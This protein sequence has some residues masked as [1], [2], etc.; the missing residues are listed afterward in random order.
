MAGLRKKGVT[1]LKILASTLLIY[2]IYTRIDLREVAE[3]LKNTDP[4][5]ILVSLLF[6]LLSKILSAIRL[7]LFFY[8]LEIGLTWQ[9]NFKL[10]LLGMFYN[11]FL[12]GGIGGDAYKGYLIRKNFDVA[13]RKV[14]S[15]LLLD[16]LSGLL[17]L[18]MYACI[19]ACFMEDGPL[20][21][22]RYLYIIMLFLSFILFRLIIHRFFN[23]LLPAF[24][25]TFGC[26]ALVQFLQLLS[27]FFIL[28]ALDLTTQSIPYLFIF[29]ISSI[30]AV[31]P[32]TLG[33]LGSREVVFYYGASWLGLNA[34]SSV[35][36]SMVFF[37]I[38]ALVSLAGILYHIKRPKLVLAADQ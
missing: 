1:L 36:V 35:T 9:S 10:Y 16:R 21:Q 24:W 38:T 7:N 23:Y 27:A 19:L 5:Y 30:V 2:F 8:Q 32:L 26:S 29:L 22:F 18:F 31:L 4:A 34:T 14:I 13:T 6:F 28:Q 12:P 15:V 25:S 37:L 17:L 3:V 11:L 33:G 20:Q